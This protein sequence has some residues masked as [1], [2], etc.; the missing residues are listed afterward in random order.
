MAAQ[1]GGR[2]QL[3]ANLIQINRAYID[4]RW[5]VELQAPLDNTELSGLLIPDSQ[6]GCGV[7]LGRAGLLDA[8]QWV[9]LPVM[10]GLA[11][12]KTDFK[13]E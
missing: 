3:P 6:Y 4:G 11:G 5:T 8:K 9:P 12:D 7:A 2:N 1:P 13:V 10:L